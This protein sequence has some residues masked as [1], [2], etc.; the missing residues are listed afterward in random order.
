MKKWILALSLVAVAGVAALS[1][2][3]YHLLSDQDRAKLNPFVKEQ[4]SYVK[5]DNS[6]IPAN[7]KDDDM[8]E[9]TLPAWS[10]NG[11]VQNTTFN[12]MK[13]LREGAYIQL[14]AKGGYVNSYKEV[15]A[16]QLPETIRSHFTEDSGKGTATSPS[17]DTNAAT[18][19]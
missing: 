7:T 5:I 1:V 18:Q 14:I 10:E 9:Y 13:K 8:V 16:D 17:D 12:G 2:G 11:T 19:Q 6:A 15:T 4:Y 3:M